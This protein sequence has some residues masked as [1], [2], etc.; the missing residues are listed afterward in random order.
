MVNP[1]TGLETR[2]NL[3]MPSTLTRRERIVLFVVFAIGLLAAT[4][5]EWGI[6]QYCLRLLTPSAST[7]SIHSR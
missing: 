3:A 2:Y 1:Q 6:P 4:V 7:S 5:H